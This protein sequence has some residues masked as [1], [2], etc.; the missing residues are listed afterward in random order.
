MGNTK[1]V[2]VIGA[3]AIGLSAAYYLS[4][5]GYRVTVLERSTRPEGCSY[6]N[7]GMIVPSHFIPLAAPGIIMKGIRWHFNPESPFHIKPSPDPELIKWLW[8]FYRSSNHKHV[9]NSASILALLNLTSRG[10]LEELNNILNFGFESKGLIMVANTDRGMREEME[11]VKLAKK[12][13]IKT[14]KLSTGDIEKLQPG[15]RFNVKGGLYFRQ[16][17]S[18]NPSLFMTR[19]LSWLRDKGIITEY[20][21][22]VKGFTQEGGKI[23]AVVTGNGVYQADEVILAAGAWSPEVAGKLGIKLPVIAGKGYSITVA[24]PVK[25]L[26]IPSILS[27]GKV[28]VTPFGNLLRFAGTMELTGSDQG[29][30]KQRVTGLIKSIRAYMPDFKEVDLESQ[31][32]WVGLRPVSADGLPYIGRFNSVNNLIAATGHSMMGISLSAVTGSI[33]EEI[34]SGKPSMF[35][36]GRLS[37]N[38]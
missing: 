7:A 6:G 14:E 8:K 19:M 28:A 9:N 10:M 27:E 24:N 13:G 23:K 3:G 22:D 35:D 5:E 33:I 18:I 21:A 25:Q 2:V 37:P 11:A 30:D 1:K 32:V 4:R 34:V 38:R 17:A 29:I 20:G 26:T 15:V 36:L 12:A 16:D 31:K